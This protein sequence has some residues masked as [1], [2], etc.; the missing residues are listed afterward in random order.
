M[1]VEDEGG[2]RSGA[3]SEEDAAA[4]VPDGSVRVRAGPPATHRVSEMAL[5][6]PL[7]L[8]L[9]PFPLLFAPLLLLLLLAPAE[10]ARALVDKRSRDAGEGRGEGVLAAEEF[11]RFSLLKLT[12]ALLLLLCGEAEG[13]EEGSVLASLRRMVEFQWFLIALSVRPGRS[14]AISAHLLP[15]C[16]CASINMLSSSSDHASFL[17]EGLRW[18]C[19]R[20]LHC[21]PILPCWRAREDKNNNFEVDLNKNTIP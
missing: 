11:S 13:E 5:L 17:I 14:L 21:L 15:S 8:P 12:L 9:A 3:G 19:H 6:A 20:S 2:G 7:P 10:G 1:G 4:H 16:L 18:L